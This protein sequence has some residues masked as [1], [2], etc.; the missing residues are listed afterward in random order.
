[1]RSSYNAASNGYNTM[2]GCICIDDY[3]AGDVGPVPNAQGDDASIP[4]A[5]NPADN[6]T[7]ERPIS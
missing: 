6:K 7:S 1:M 2:V 3:V 4:E 5:T